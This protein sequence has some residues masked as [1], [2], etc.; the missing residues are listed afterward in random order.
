MINFFRL[1]LVGNL[2]HAENILEERKKKKGKDGERKK[3]RTYSMSP[4]G[5]G[6]LWVTPKNRVSI[7]VDNLAIFC[8]LKFSLFTEV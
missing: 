4:W 2:S 1:G 8:V 5:P 6:M 3:L 7:F